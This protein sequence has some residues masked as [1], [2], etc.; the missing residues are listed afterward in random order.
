M[1]KITPVKTFGIIKYHNLSEALDRC[2]S[3]SG[4]ITDINN[5][6]VR[7]IM[8]RCLQPVKK[9]NARYLGFVEDI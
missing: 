8:H 3:S 1:E 4:K 5:Y 7:S 6:E 2:Y 9:Q